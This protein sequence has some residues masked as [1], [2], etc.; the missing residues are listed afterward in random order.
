MSHSLL[1]ESVSLP[2]LFLK[3]AVHEQREF[4]ARAGFLFPHQELL[5]I[6]RQFPRGG[7]PELPLPGKGLEND[8]F[9]FRGKVGIQPVADCVYSFEE[10]EE[11]FVLTYKMTSP[12][13]ALWSLD[14]GFALR[15]QAGGKKTLHQSRK[16]R[17]GKKR[18]SINPAKPTRR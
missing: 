6:R 10:D 18:R 3:K 4:F 8:P 16:A 13:F 9:K 7:V 2:L 1:D 17:G 11:S 5:Q 14:G 15:R 12:G